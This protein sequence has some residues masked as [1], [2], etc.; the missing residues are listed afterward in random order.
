MTTSAKDQRRVE[1]ARTAAAVLR[2]LLDEVLSGQLPAG[3]RGL[4]HRLEGA[5]AAY[6]ALDAGIQE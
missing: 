6:D 3:R 4:V 5:I 2:R 1:D